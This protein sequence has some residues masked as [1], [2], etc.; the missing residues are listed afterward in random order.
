MLQSITVDLLVL[1]TINGRRI[2]DP[3]SGDPPSRSSLRLRSTRFLKAICCKDYQS[4][5][6]LNCQHRN[7]KSSSVT[8]T[9][10][11]LNRYDTLAPNYFT[12]TSN[13]YSGTS[14][15]VSKR[16]QFDDYRL[17]ALSAQ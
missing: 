14:V 15:Y 16:L 4:H 1:T 13:N 5:T 12:Q 9:I 7:S 17:T 6:F 8:V 3:G 10:K 2:T 11:R